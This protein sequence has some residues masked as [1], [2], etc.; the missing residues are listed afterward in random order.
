MKA[1]PCAS[2]Y[3]HGVIQIIKTSNLG[4]FRYGISIDKGA[5]A[6]FKGLLAIRPFEYHVS[7]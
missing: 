1:Y 6:P 4:E 3:I 7:S 5:V 2:I